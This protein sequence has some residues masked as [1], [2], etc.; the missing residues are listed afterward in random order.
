MPL[1]DVGAANEHVGRLIEVLAGR[2]RRDAIDVVKDVISDGAGGMNACIIFWSCGNDGSSQ[3]GFIEMNMVSY[4]NSEFP[5]SGYQHWLAISTPKRAMQCTNVL[6][7][8]L[9]A[10]VSKLH[11]LPR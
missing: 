5:I 1:A 2:R 10:G 9:H 11:F 7:R 3:S 6:H 4:G 8:G